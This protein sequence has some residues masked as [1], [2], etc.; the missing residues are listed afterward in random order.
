[1]ALTVKVG[2][3]RNKLSRYLKKVREGREIV[4]TDRETPIGRVIPYKK[5]KSEEVLTIQ[6]PPE[7]YEGLA[8]L[9][10]PDLPVKVDAVELLLEDRRRR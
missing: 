8:K 5:G 3:F 2:E 9:S 4:I 6:E 1:M 7:G 10:F